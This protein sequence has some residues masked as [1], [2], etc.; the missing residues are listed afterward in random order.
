[1]WHP[2]ETNELYVTALAARI[3]DILHNAVQRDGAACMAVSGG[4]S[5]IALFQALNRADIAW[6]HVR[7]RL[8]DERFVDPADPDSN[9]H[10]V[11][12]NLLQNKAAAA[13]FTGLVSDPATLDRSLEQA[14]KQPDRL[15]T[16]TQTGRTAGGARR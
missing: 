6:E 13:H 4:H 7:I 14:N 1:M 11:R 2:F 5:P 8:V 15:T 3:A 16:A 10:L 9:E 12:T